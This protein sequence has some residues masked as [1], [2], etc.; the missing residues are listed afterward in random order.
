[1]SL[2][3]LVVLMA[4]I[5]AGEIT[6]CHRQHAVDTAPKL[7]TFMSR[8]DHLLSRQ[9]PESQ[10]VQVPAPEPDKQDGQIR[11][12]WL[13]GSISIEP[14][15]VDEPGVAD[16]KLKGARIGISEYYWR[17]TSPYSSTQQG[18]SNGG[19]SLLDEDELRDL[20]QSLKLM[21]VRAAEWNNKP[22]SLRSELVFV[23]KD[24]FHVSL[25]EDGARHSEFYIGS[26][27][28]SMLLSSGSMDR[29]IAGVDAAI[30]ELQ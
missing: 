6:G 22:P 17:I 10:H 27:N 1:M 16:S 18:Q 9:F 11:N 26:E 20:Q 25:G 3:P 21:K 12:V 14:I 28:A 30:Q 15:I 19:D 23:A 4:A 8:T 5:S 24:N 2:K 29:L 7:K 13:P